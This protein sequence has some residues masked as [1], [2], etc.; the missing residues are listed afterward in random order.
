MISCMAV[1]A[2]CMRAVVEKETRVFMP[3]AVHI[4]GKQHSNQAAMQGCSI[5][6][7]N[8]V[9]HGTLACAH[10]GYST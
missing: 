3:E 10:V 7:W 4:S 1:P 2:W 8:A 6:A 5:A 9:W